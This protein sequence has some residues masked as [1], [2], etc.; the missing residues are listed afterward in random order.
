MVTHVTADCSIN[1]TLYLYDSPLQ[2]RGFN[3]LLGPVPSPGCV[4]SRLRAH[5]D[6][7]LKTNKLRNLGSEYKVRS[8]VARIREHTAHREDT[9]TR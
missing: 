5:Q 8:T 6:S 7:G 4:L 9:T 3:R 2:Q 1:H